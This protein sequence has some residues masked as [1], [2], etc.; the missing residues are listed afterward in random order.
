MVSTELALVPTM[1]WTLLLQ[2]FCVSEYFSHSTAPC[3]SFTTDL[4]PVFSGCDIFSWQAETYL[5]SRV[6]LPDSS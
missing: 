3:F 5:S 6:S 4:R 2:H 1:P